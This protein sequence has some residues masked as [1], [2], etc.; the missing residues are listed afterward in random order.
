LALKVLVANR[1]LE[2]IIIKGL[3]LQ[4]SLSFDVTVTI[5]I[6]SSYL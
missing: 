2:V 5:N 6:Q 4:L 3:C 1:D